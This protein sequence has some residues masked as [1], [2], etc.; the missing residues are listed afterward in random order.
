ME[1]E[2]PL[3]FLQESATRLYGKQDEYNAISF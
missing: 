3:L 2:G 1:Q